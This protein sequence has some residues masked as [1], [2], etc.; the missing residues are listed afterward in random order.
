MSE[1]VQMEKPKEKVPSD[2][3]EVEDSLK[4]LA[5]RTNKV[6]VRLHTLQ[7]RV[8]GVNTESKPEMSGTSIV[9]EGRSRNNR[10]TTLNNPIRDTYTSLHEM[11]ECLDYLEQTLG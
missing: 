10:V 11:E 8:M 4:K 6:K 3:M 2:L 9:I 1:L 7:E 5:E